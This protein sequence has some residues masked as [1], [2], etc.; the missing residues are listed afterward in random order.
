MGAAVLCSWTSPQRASSWRCVIGCVCGVFVFCGLCD[1]ALII[2][3]AGHACFCRYRHVFL[4]CVLLE[5]NL[6]QY[7]SVLSAAAVET[8]SMCVN[9]L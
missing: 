1:C 7:D 4:C 9:E 2:I 8:C 3:A 6:S 5:L